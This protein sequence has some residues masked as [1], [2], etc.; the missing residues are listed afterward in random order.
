MTAPALSVGLAVRNGMRT[1]ERCIA[2]VLAQDLADIELVIGDNASDDGTRPLL[3]DYAR[4]DP[5]IRLLL[6]ES[7][8]GIDENMKLVL[9]RSAGQ[10]FRWISADDW[11]EPA[12]FSSCARM[13]DENL[14]AIGVTTGFTIHTPDGAT[15]YEDFAGPFPESM[16]PGL[17]FERMLWFFHAGDARYDPVYGV[18]RREAL[19]RCR[20]MRPSE[21][22]DWLLSAELALRGPILHM[23]QRLAHRTR[24][25]ERVLDAA[26]ARR[27][28]DPARGEQI[29]TSAWR[30]YRQMQ[31]LAISADLSEEQMRRCQRA[32]QRF[33]V[34]ETIRT[35]RLV[36]ADLKHR[37][38]SR[39]G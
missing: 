11:L 20:P 6:N 25:Y 32:L 22:A 16:D 28:L 13:L 18:Y 17:R 7:N 34:K 27:R 12:C 37:W 35:N 5:R 38:L 4:R 3:Q 26:A 14:Q 30:L 24:T 8:I 31:A 1:V 15:R 9:Q 33:L 29:R 36:L 23:P 2:S 10:L 21:R 39:L 19:L